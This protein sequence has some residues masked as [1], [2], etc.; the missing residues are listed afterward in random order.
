[1]EVV[2][3][4]EE[5]KSCIGCNS[6]ICYMPY[7][8]NNEIQTRVPSY[9]VRVVEEL[10]PVR[11]T[12]SPFDFLDQFLFLSPKQ[13]HSP[14]C[15]YI[16]YTSRRHNI[17]HHL[18]DFN[19]ATILKSAFLYLTFPACLLR[20]PSEVWKNICFETPCRFTETMSFLFIFLTKFSCLLHN[21]NRVA[22]T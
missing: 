8:I 7:E 17:L 19:L 2:E 10:N 22:R 12:I 6:L 9:I 13:A 15:L 16:S 11:S 20:E 5:S 14:Y 21:T 18:E 3:V 1:M 4:V